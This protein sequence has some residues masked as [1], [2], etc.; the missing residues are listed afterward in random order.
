MHIWVRASDNVPR[1]LTVESVESDESSSPI[2]TYDFTDWNSR[3]LVREKEMC[4]CVCV[5]EY[6]HLADQHNCLACLSF[7]LRS[8]CLVAILT[9][10]VSDILG[11]G[12][13]SICFTI[14]LDFKQGIHIFV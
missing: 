9:R 10:H 1:R 6:C 7:N 11:V 5:C 8:S 14:F 3:P 4:V 2:M 12:R 13:T